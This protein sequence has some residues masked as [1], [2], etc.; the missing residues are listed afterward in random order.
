MSV[1]VPKTSVSAASPLGRYPKGLCLCSSGFNRRT[2]LKHPL[3]IKFAVGHLFEQLLELVCKYLDFRDELI[4]ALKNMVSAAKR[5]R[6][7]AN[8][9]KGDLLNCQMN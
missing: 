7:E 8:V 9:T 6:E 1:S 5:L 4:P 3:R 2:L